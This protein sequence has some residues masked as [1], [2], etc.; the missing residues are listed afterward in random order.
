MEEAINA[1]RP[2]QVTFRCDGC[3]ALAA[4]SFSRGG[5]WLKPQSWFERSDKDG[6]QLA[7]SRACIDKVAKDSGKTGCVLPI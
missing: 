2:P 3:G 4:G 5:N 7:C 1:H 6:A